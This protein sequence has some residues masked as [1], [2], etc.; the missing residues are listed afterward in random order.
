MKKILFAFC[1]VSTSAF[2]IDF[3]TE[4][5]AMK[6][7]F[8]KVTPAPVAVV[9]VV[10]EAPVVQVVTESI[11]LKRM[12]PRSPNLL[13]YT[14]SDPVMRNRVTELYKRP[15]VIVLSTTIY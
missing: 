3:D 12:D 11:D 8:A 5:K 7:V 14:L 13:G 1:F 2:A 4:W 9:S 6:V 10:P 15:D